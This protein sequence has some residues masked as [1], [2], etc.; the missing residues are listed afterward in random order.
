MQQRSD[1]VLGSRL[2]YQ[3]LVQRK[4]EEDEVKIS[5]G[6]HRYQGFDG[7]DFSQLQPLPR[8]PNGE[9]PYGTWLFRPLE[10]TFPRVD[11]VIVSHG[12][13]CKKVIAIQ[14]TV[15]EP[16]VHAAGSQSDWKGFFGVAAAAGQ[17]SSAVTW[18]HLC[19]QLAINID[20]W[21]CDY[22]DITTSEEP[23]GIAD[24]KLAQLPAGTLIG[25]MKRK[26]LSCWGIIS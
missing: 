2:V 25:V 22:I 9:V 8:L 17:N 16:N 5:I 1:E 14:S 4:Q 10:K 15:S 20:Q 21:F 12:I 19:T 7:K 18:T 23:K 26:H 13:N 24:D 3:P 11:F 6:D